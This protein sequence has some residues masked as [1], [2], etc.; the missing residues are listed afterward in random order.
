MCV[1]RNKW[2][3]VIIPAVSSLYCAL[4]WVIH[5]TNI[6]LQPLLKDAVNR[7]VMIDEDWVISRRSHV[8]HYSFLTVSKVIVKPSYSKYNVN[9]KSVYNYVC[10]G[11][12][13]CVC[14]K[15]GGGLGLGLGNFWK[16]LTCPSFFLQAEFCMSTCVWIN[17][18]ANCR[19]CI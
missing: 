13:E 9:L 17:L 5:I 15:E 19:F 4:V 1:Q 3:N 11:E 14:E 18:V 6:P 7:C 10:V 12:E 2:Y 16:Y 8:S